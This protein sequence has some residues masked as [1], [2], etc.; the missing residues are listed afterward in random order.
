MTETEK[1]TEFDKN[2]VTPTGKQVFILTF[3]LCLCAAAFIVLCALDDGRMKEVGEVAVTQ[4]AGVKTEI[5]EAQMGDRIWFR[6]CY[7]FI[8]GESIRTWDLQVL[9]EEEDS[10]DAVSIPTYMIENAAMKEYFAEG[11][12]TYLRVG[13]SANV[14]ASRIDLASHNYKV[15]LYYNNNEHDLYV[16][17]GYVLTENGVRR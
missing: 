17:T 8:P 5:P 14:K 2:D 1:K 3:I 16:D 12:D 9:L 4:D 13:F 15:L 7:A 11:D 6:N 10:G